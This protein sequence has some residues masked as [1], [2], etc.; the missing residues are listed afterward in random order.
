MVKG[1][2]EAVGHVD[3][4]PNE[5]MEQPGCLTT[6]CSHHRAWLYFTESVINQ[7]AFPAVKCDSWD[8]FKKGSCKDNI[9]YMGF[10]SKPGTT[11]KH[12]LQTADEVP[13]SL[14]V[15]G[16]AYRNTKGIVGN[17]ADVLLG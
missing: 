4:Y 3:Y 17:I 7:K 16:T 6:H 9:S 11:G 15:N 8:E 1:L 5:G 2:I 10:P 14:G 13:F 12:Y